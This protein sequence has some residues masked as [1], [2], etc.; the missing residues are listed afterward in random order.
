MISFRYTS[1]I[2][3]TCR[4]CVRSYNIEYNPLSKCNKVFPRKEQR[5]LIGKVV[6]HGNQTV[7]VG[8]TTNWNWCVYFRQTTPG[9]P[10]HVLV[11]TKFTYSYVLYVYKTLSCQTGSQQRSTQ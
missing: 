8:R 1:F 9:I 6:G 2:P 11:R 5:E 10:P 3:A 7:G 4:I